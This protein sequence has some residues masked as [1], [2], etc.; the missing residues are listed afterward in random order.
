MDLEN[1]QVLASFFSIEQMKTLRYMEV[2]FSDL[3][4]EH[5]VLE[6]AYM[7]KGLAWQTNQIWIQILILLTTSCVIL[8]KLLPS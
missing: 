3:L 5:V 2:K 7:A 4:E 1:F 6:R 8:D